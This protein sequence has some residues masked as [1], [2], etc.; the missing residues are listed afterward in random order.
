MGM[1]NM[2]DEEVPDGKDDN[3]NVEM[4]TIGSIPK[5]NFNPLDHL[6]LRQSA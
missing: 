1:P 2:P 3:D 4:R 6:E 5:F